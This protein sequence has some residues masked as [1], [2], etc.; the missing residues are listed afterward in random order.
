MQPLKIVKITQKQK[1]IVFVQKHNSVLIGHMSDGTIWCSMLG[2]TSWVFVWLHSNENVTL[3]RWQYPYGK[4]THFILP[5]WWSKSTI[6]PGKVSHLDFQGLFWD[7]NMLVSLHC[8]TKFLRIL[9]SLHSPK[10]GR[11]C[12]CH[13]LKPLCVSMEIQGECLF[14]LSSCSSR[15]RLSMYCRYQSPDFQGLETVSWHLSITCQ[16]HH[17]QR[18]ELWNFD[19]VA[20][21]RPWLVAGSEQSNVV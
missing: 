5:L 10:R 8:E 1:K 19:L 21:A 18:K 14:S 4:P 7:R 17:S 3:T 11:S 15:S 6:Q 20:T 2:A 12:M 16:W 13:F 9:E